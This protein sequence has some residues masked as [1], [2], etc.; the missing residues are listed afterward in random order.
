MSFDHLARL[1]KV[2]LISVSSSRVSFICHVLLCIMSGQKIFKTSQMSERSMRSEGWTL[3]N[4]SIDGGGGRTTGGG[5]KNTD[6]QQSPWTTSDGAGAGRGYT[7][8]MGV[9]SAVTSVWGELED[10][11]HFQRVLCTR[12]M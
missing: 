9:K 5:I 6:A 8:P 3:E 11:P 2:R 4:R 1:L 12:F 10:T 7:A